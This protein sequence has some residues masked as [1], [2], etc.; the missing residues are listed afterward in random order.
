MPYWTHKSLRRCSRAP[1]DRPRGTRPDTIAP[2]P[3][4]PHCPGAVDRVSREDD[5]G[6]QFVL[7]VLLGDTR[8]IAM[9]VAAPRVDR[10]AMTGGR[11]VAE[12]VVGT[13]PAGGHADD[14]HRLRIE[15]PAGGSRQNRDRLTPSL[16]PTSEEK[17][18]AE[19]GREGERWRKPP[20]D[21]GGRRKGST[22]RSELTNEANVAW[23]CRSS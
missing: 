16:S 13:V 11:D 18:K 1:S 20:G 10:A 23:A 4:R 5:H 19:G 21:E 3:L 14:R 7:D 8:T 15:G 22:G 12:N 9:L 2:A 6:G 17:G